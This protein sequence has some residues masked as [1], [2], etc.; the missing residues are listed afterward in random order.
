[1]AWP[2]VW[3]EIWMQVSIVIVQIV[4]DEVALNQILSCRGCNEID[5]V[6]LEADG[7]GVVGR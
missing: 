1:M 6:D 7:V 4:E 3:S 2:L 5:D